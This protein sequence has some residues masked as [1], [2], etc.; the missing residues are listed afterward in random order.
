MH[1]ADGVAASHL[2][3]RVRLVLASSSPFPD[4]GS[5]NVTLEPWISL[6]DKIFKTCLIKIFY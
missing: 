4:E 1:A 5:G 2:H 6:S 3:L